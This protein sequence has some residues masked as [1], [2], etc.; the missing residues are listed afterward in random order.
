[1]RR[2]FSRKKKSGRPQRG[3]QRQDPVARRSGQDGEDET[4]M[5]QGR[6]RTVGFGSFWVLFAVKKYRAAAT[7]GS[8]A[9]IPMCVNSLS[10][11]TFLILFLNFFKLH[12]SHF[13]LPKQNNPPNS[14]V[15]CFYFAKVLS[16]NTNAYPWKKPFNDKHYSR[17]NYFSAGVIFSLSTFRKR[18]NPLE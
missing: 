7:V 18:L 12:P 8:V 1:M 17:Q 4:W 13:K 9:Q 15:V 2:F 5:H 14:R 6:F 16:F 3:H 10:F 11:H